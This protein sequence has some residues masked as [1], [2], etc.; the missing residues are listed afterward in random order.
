MFALALASALTG[1]SPTAGP[2]ASPGWVVRVGLSAEQLQERTGEMRSLGYRPAGISAYNAAEANR[3][4]VIYEKSKGPAWDLNW[5]LTLDQFLERARRLR[6]AGYVPVCLSGCNL[7]GAERLSDLWLKQAGP[8]RELSRGL[9]GDS[10]IREA[11]RRRERGYRPVWISSY[12][13]GGLNSYAAIWEKNG[14]VPW[15]LKYGLSAQQLQDALDDLSARGFRP[16]TISGLNA[17]GVARYCAV[18]EKRK[19]PAW[20][21]KFGQTQEELLDLARSMAARGYRPLAVTGYNTLDGD[22]FASV[23]A[24]EPG[25]E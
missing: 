4:A 20:L 5:G 2:P 23:W 1:L 21:A 6:A 18:W 15:E 9:D 10:L 3:F 25:T 14:D 24:Q 11:N 17:G 19:G 22:R 12:M 16:I 8:D 7:I 13:A